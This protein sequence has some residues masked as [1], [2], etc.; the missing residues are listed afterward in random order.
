MFIAI[1]EAKV[2]PVTLSC[3]GGEDR[4]LFRAI[5]APYACQAYHVHLAAKA[6]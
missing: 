4:T 6:A 3:K 5:P 2:D 1:K